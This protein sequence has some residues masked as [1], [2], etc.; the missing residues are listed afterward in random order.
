MDCEAVMDEVRNP[1]RLGGVHFWIEAFWQFAAEL[2]GGDFS[3]RIFARTF[4]VL[5][6]EIGV[7]AVNECELQVAA[8]VVVVR[9][10]IENND[11][12]GGQFRGDFGYL[13]AAYAAVEELR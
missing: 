1:P 12:E 10:R 6:R 11:R 2:V 4:G 13:A 3:L 5:P 9:V 8:D 7:H